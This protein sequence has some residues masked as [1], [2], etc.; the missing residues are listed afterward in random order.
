[1]SR[2]NRYVINGIPHHAFQRGNNGQNIFRQETDKMFFI[3]HLARDAKENKVN[4]GSYCLMTNH[5][6]F[7]LFPE[8][9]DG[10]ITLMK[11]V[12]QRYSQY[13]NWKYKRTGKIW[14]NRYK[15]NLV[16]PESAWLVARYIERNPVRA[17][18]VERAEEYEYSSAAQHLS[19]EKNALVT[20][21]ILKNSRESYIRFFY[22]KDA[23]DKKKL[24]QMRTII[25]QQKAIGS[26]NFLE[27]L[28]KEFKVDFNVR[29][30]GRPKK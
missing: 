9:R 13:F 25:Q 7:L 1:M 8:T 22:E 26:D 23:D 5:F 15:L 11:S 24:D 16:E 2:K 21:D 30:R 27:K 20:E 14:E 10:L 6:H 18:M 29:M 12:S 4:I 28:K 19:G 17:R 3:K